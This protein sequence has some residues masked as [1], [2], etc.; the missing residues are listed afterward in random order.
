MST[1][2]YVAIGGVLAGQWAI[3]TPEEKG[4]VWSITLSIAD[5]FAQDNELFN[6]KKFYNYVF[7]VEDQF[8]ARNL[9]KFR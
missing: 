2:D 8:K 9:C 6:R 3:S 7:G 4:T 1:K 5:K